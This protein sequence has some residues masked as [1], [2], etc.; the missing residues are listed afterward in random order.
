[1]DRHMDNKHSDRLNPSADGSYRCLGDLCGELGCGVYSDEGC[2]HNL[3]GS[4]G[5]GGR[6]GCRVCDKPEMARRQIRCK[7]LFHR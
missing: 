1:M 3:S 2:G 7:T 5:G 6:I 4:G